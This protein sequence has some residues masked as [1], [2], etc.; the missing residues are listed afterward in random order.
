MLTW[1]Q[2]VEGGMSYAATKLE[3]PELKEV[4]DKAYRLVKAGKADMDQMMLD[5]HSLKPEVGELFDAHGM[6]KLN[7]W[8]NTANILLIHQN[9]PNLDTAPL[10]VRD[11]NRGAGV[12]TAGGTAYSD[13]FY[14]LTGGYKKPLRDGLKYVICCQPLTMAGMPPILE[15]KLPGVK[16]LGNDEFAAYFNTTY[17]AKPTAGNTGNDA[18]AQM[19]KIK[20]YLVNKVGLNDKAVDVTL[21]KDGKNIFIRN[22]Y[23]GDS[24]YVPVGATDDQMKAAAKAAFKLA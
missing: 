2:F 24:K 6:A 1:Q 9:M 3:D 11:E 23:S 16:V 19:E 10:S 4:C 21:S 12:F 14:I 15:K 13:G 7:Y 5:M 20:N 17:K 22:R 8:V 18:N